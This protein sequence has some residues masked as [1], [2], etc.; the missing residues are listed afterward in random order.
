MI[1]TNEFLKLI[2]L[3]PG[4]T[5]RDCHNQ[6][7]IW[8]L[9]GKDDHPYY[10]ARYLEIPDHPIQIAEYAL[11]LAK[12]LD[13]VFN[14]ESVLRSKKLRTSFQVTLPD[15]HPAL[16]LYLGTQLEVIGINHITK[17]LTFKIKE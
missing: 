17:T 14:E 13:E 1:D 3:P 4:V 8:G 7:V 6:H 2:P 9:G 10:W 16:Y 5:V 12:E 15:N 11:E